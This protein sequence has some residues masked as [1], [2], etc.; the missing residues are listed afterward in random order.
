MNA[1]WDSVT[2]QALTSTE[3]LVARVES[4][5]LRP[6]WAVIRSKLLRAQQAVPVEGDVIKGEAKKV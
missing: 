1:G 2:F 4:G 5:Q 3:R 6:P